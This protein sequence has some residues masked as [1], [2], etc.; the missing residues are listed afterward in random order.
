MWDVNYAPLKLTY[1]KTGQVVMFKGAD[2]P[3]KLKSIKVA[4]GYIKY[5]WYEE[6]NEFEGFEKI[7]NI[8]QSVVRGGSSFLIFYSFNPPESQRNWANAEVLEERADKYVHH[9]DYR[10]VPKTWLGEQFIIEAEHLKKAKPQQ[11]KH[12]YLG[13]VIGTGGEVFMNITVR[14]IKD[15]EI[16]VFDRIKRGMDFGYAADPLAY[17][18]CQYDKTRKR[19]YIFHEIYQR[20]L[21]NEKA[22]QL[23]K[24][25]NTSNSLVTADSA[26]PRT[27]AEFQ[28][29]GLNIIGA[30][31]GKDSVEHGVKF[32]SETVEEIVIDPVRC[33]NAKREFL[34]Y[35]LEKDKDGNFKGSYPDKNNHT[36]DAVRY[37]LEA[38]MIANKVQVF[39]KRKFGLG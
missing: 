22:V 24:S 26:E 36:I 7:R 21:G 29:L 3:I 8:N 38:D 19:L 30:K 4:K 20:Q 5:L 18:A 31:K 37:A 23:I 39:D 2:N 11:Y 28:R 6:V 14:K 12:E 13:E 17:V 9:S 25:E 10:S 34:E 35:E 16:K 1:R 33:P 32:L 15:E 27:I